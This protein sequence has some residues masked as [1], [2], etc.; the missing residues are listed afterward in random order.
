VR[1]NKGKSLEHPGVRS[2]EQAWSII[3]LQDKFLSSPLCFFKG[4]GKSIFVPMLQIWR[5]WQRRAPCHHALLFQCYKSQGHNNEEFGSSL[6]CFLFKCCKSQGPWRW[7]ARLFFIMHSFVLMLQVPWT[8]QW[9]AWFLVIVF[10]F[11][12]VLDIP[13]AMTTR[14]WTPH[15]CAFFCSSAIGSRTQRWK[16]QLFIIMFFLFKC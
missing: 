16:I 10:F 7:G 5:S 3:E 4:L 9:R 2:L 13:R 12:Q 8:R 11:V 1:R 6:L 15:H 14:S